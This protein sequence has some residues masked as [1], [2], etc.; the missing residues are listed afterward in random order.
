MKNYKKNQ[1]VDIPQLIQNLDK[2]HLEFKLENAEMTLYLNGVKIDKEIRTTEVS[3]HVSQIA[4][5]KEIRTFLIKIQRDMA[6]NGGVIMDGRDIGTSILPDADYKFFMTA[7]VDVRTER[8]YQELLSLGM[9]VDKS[10][11]KKNLIERD[12]IDSERKI[13]PLKQADD[14]ILVDNSN[15]DKNQTLDFILSKIL[16]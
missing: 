11:V 5:Q 10:E 8:R 1:E 4:Q 16:T 3:N 2:I 9:E 14:A 6:K 15:M 13:S 7:N 12:K